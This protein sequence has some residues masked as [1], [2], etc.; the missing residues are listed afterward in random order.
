ME[1]L[2][3]NVKNA[4]GSVVTLAEILEQLE[5]AAERAGGS[6]RIAGDLIEIFGQRA[7]P[8]MVAL[9]SQGSDALRA[10]TQ[11][12]KESGGT[13][14]RI[15]DVQMEGYIGASKRMQAAIEGMKI[16]IGNRLIP[17]FEKLSALVV[18]LS[19]RWGKLDESTKNFLITIAGVVAV[20]G[21]LL[22][23]LSLASTLIA[24]WTL[25]ATAIIAV[26]VAGVVIFRNWSTLAPKLAD[27][28]FAFVDFMKAVLKDLISEAPELMFRLG[29]FL[30]EGLSIAAE[31]AKT[32]AEFA[33]GF[34]FAGIKDL[35]EM[36]IRD[37]LNTVKVLVQSLGAGIWSALPEEWQTELLI[38]K[39]RVQSAF[40]N[41][42]AIVQDLFDFNLDTGASIFDSLEEGWNAAFGLARKGMQATKN[43]IIDTLLTIRD[44]IANFFSNFTPTGFIADFLSLAKSNYLALKPLKMASVVLAAPSPVCLRLKPMQQWKT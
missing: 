41:V 7:G 30:V 34:L 2:G 23:V 31:N 17:I 43:F 35:W 21:P 15:A 8:A 24:P 38:L 10:F 3:I 19:E 9:M 29:Q 4:N 33:F 13:A 14:K 44:A 26:G 42:K 39:N 25:L 6:T 18:T 32:F 40:D 1:K 37:A 11:E 28:W 12:L 16:D 36:D 27:V 22:V 20:I 5:G